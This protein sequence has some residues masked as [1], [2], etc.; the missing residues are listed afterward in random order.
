MAQVFDYTTAMEQ[1]AALQALDGDDVNS[2]CRSGALT[3]GETTDDAIVL[4]HGMTNCPQ[5]FSD[6]APLLYARGYNVLVPR[7]PHNGLADR[8]TRALAK[9]TVAELKAYGEQVTDIARGL[10]RRVTIL[11]ISAG[12]VIAAWLAQFRSDVDR[13]VVVAPVF[14]ILPELPSAINDTANWLTMQILLALPN[15]MT[16]SFRPFK[17]GPDYGYLGFSSRSLGTVMRLGQEVFRAA[18]ATAPAARSIVV[19]S[20]QNDEAVNDR[21]TE[22]LVERWR[23]HGAQASIYTF[24]RSERLGH[25]IIDPRQPNQRTSYVYPILLDLITGQTTAPV[26]APSH[27]GAEG[28]AIAN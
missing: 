8:N 7:Q 10:G 24:A 3:H 1:L 22:H 21:M 4:I 27:P 5:Q 13:A 17:E 28:S 23:A 15:I 14:G 26:N 12:A 25:D 19:T 6:F 11:G 16:Q 2:V 18:K 9:L 20:N